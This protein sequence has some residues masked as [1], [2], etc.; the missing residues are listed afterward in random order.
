MLVLRQK[1]QLEAM[2]WAEHSRL[3]VIVRWSEHTVAI[4]TL[5]VQGCPPGLAHPSVC[6]MLLWIMNTRRVFCKA[7]FQSEVKMKFSVGNDVP[8]VPLFWDN[9]LLLVKCITKILLGFVAS[10]K[11]KLKV[12]YSSGHGRELWKKL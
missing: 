2:A 12:G 11:Q 9:S 10:Q 5:N 3:V 7:V 8:F 6:C 1:N 4:E